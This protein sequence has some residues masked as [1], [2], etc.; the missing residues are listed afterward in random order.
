MLKNNYHFYL[1]LILISLSIAVLEM[2]AGAAS[3]QMMAIHMGFHCLFFFGLMIGSSDFIETKSM[4]TL[5]GILLGLFSAFR[6]YETYQVF[7]VG[8]AEDYPSLVILVIIIGLLWLQSFLLHR[9]GRVDKKCNALCHVAGIH[10]RGDILV[11]GIIGIMTL[12]QFQGAWI[13]DQVLS[14]IVL[15]IMWWFFIARIWRK[16]EQVESL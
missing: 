4:V 14:L 6:I 3:L 8:H 9:L 7:A 11:T 10:I 15:S 2:T 13:I 12:L 5:I 16:G 1:P